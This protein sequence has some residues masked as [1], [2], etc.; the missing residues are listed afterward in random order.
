MKLNDRDLVAG[1]AAAVA[2]AAASTA[3]AQ[4]N[5]PKPSYKFEKCY[6][7]ASAGQNDC[8]STSHQCG[9]TAELDHDPD[10]W[11]Y[12]P[13]GVCEKIAGGSTAPKPKS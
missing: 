13:A 7:V 5:V 1:I 4:E 10:A 2:L 8:F 12:V 6:G 3:H 9:G 11:I